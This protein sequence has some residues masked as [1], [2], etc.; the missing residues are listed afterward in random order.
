[1]E[2]NDKEKRDDHIHDQASALPEPLPQ[3]TMDE[4]KRDDHDHYA[5]ALPEPS[6]QPNLDDVTKRIEE[7][8]MEMERALPMM[9]EATILN[10]TKMLND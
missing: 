6:P 8:M 4:E 2:G 10:M 9:T 3:T 7:M 1:M 5:S